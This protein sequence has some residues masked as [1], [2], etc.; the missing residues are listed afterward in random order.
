MNKSTKKR[1]KT[2]KP[3]ASRAGYISDS[4]LHHK[5]QAMT[6]GKVSFILSILLAV[7]MTGNIIQACNK[8]PPKYFASTPDLRLVELTP[9]DKPTLSQGGLLNWAAGAV[10]DTLSLDFLD[11]RKD[12]MS[13]KQ[14][15]FQDAFD[16]VITSLKSSGILTLVKDKRL[17][18]QTLIESAPVIT[19][20][21]LMRGVVSWKIEFPILLSYESSRGVEKTQHLIVSMLVQRVSTLE[22][23]RGVKI[24]QLNLDNR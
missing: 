6:F 4:I 11:W 16:G 3:Q 18:I 20:E 1:P 22:H 7:S 23:P 5:N 10:T 21:G 14:N 12:L 9:L 13:V 24:K 17:N 2:P 15:Y 8:T 19:A